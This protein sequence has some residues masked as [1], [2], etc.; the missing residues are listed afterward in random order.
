MGVIHSVD[1]WLGAVTVTLVYLTYVWS[2]AKLE[3]DRRI[4]FNG[5]RGL[6]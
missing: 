3:S 4:A 6:E 1:G 5:F 2:M